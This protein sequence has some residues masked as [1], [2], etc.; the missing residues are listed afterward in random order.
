M[1][2]WVKPATAPP[3]SFCQIL[4]PIFCLSELDRFI[5]TACRCAAFTK[6]WC[7][8]TAELDEHETDA[9]PIRAAVKMKMA[10]YACILPIQYA[11]ISSLQGEVYADYS[12]VSYHR[13]LSR[14]DF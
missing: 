8:L 12:K 3:D 10:G 11:V 9:H 13:G 14:F 4:L 5:A 6:G 2:Q 1:F 7:E